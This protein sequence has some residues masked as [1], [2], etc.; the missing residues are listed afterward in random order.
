LNDREYYLWLNEQKG[1]G[2]RTIHRLLEYFDSPK[3]VY[4]ASEREL[5]RLKEHFQIKQS[6][7]ATLLSQ[8]NPADIKKRSAMLNEAGISYVTIHD[9]KYPGRL[10]EI[11]EPPLILYYKGTLPKED[12]VSVSIVGARNCSNYGRVVAESIS[13]GLA[14]CGI[15][16]ISGMA[17]GIDTYAH[18]GALRA[19]GNTYAVLG[20]GVD[21]CYPTENIG[22]YMDIQKQG[23]VLSEFLPGTQGSPGTFPM[24]NR[25][26]SGLSDGVLIIEAKKKSGSLITAKWALEQGKDVFAVPGSILGEESRGCNNLIKEGAM[27]VDSKE[28][29]LTYYGITD[30][31]DL[32]AKKPNNLLDSKE[33]MVYSN[34]CLIPRHVDQIAKDSGYSAVETMR[35]L[36]KLES[37]HIIKRT[38][39]QY[40]SVIVE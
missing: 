18:R 17:R 33:E 13:A 15:Q 20:C 8:R 16:I 21:I 37:L 9:A 1:I 5:N 30:R 28:D 3:A 35:I 36:V 39:M 12:R 11:Y 10:K 23:C 22:L 7:I 29:I 2:I 6:Q 19:H 4:E 34:V 27:L 31:K 24:R 14:D 25:I 26:I 40:F 32:T 38:G